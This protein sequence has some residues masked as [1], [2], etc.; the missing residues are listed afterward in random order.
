MQAT[1]HPGSPRRLGT[2]RP[3]LRDLLAPLALALWLTAGAPS[4]LAAPQVD[5]FAPRSGPPGTTITVQGSGF[6]TGDAL[7]VFALPDPMSPRP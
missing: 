3:T 1:R 5:D 6:G 7:V 4:A 2:V